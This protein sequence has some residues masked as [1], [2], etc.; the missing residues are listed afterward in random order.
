MIALIKTA[1]DKYSSEKAAW[2][3]ICLLTLNALIHILHQD[4]YC[5]SMD[6]I[7]WYVERAA[8]AAQ[9]TWSYWLIN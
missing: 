4:M 7:Y 8:D 2:S 5:E 6:D 1:S 3:M 9:G